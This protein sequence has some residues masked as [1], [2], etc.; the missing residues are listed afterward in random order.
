MLNIK[1][2]AFPNKH[3]RANGK[4]GEFSSDVIPFERGVCPFPA[5]FK[6]DVRQDKFSLVRFWTFLLFEELNAY[7][8]R[9][10]EFK[11]HSFAPDN[12][13]KLLADNQR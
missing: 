11:S 2:I 12:L 4:C 10:Q 1:D 8:S 9:S 3:M 6:P 5:T 7:L 13:P